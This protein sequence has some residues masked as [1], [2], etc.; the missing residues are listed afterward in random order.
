MSSPLSPF[1]ALIAAPHHHRLIQENDQVRI[2]ETL[3]KPGETVPLHTHEWPAVTTILSWSDFIWRDERGEVTLDTVGQGLR[4]E[5]GE[6]SWSD[7]LPLHSLENVGGK[8]L[9]VI[10]VE[11]KPWC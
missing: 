4:N 7:P 11:I 3:V 1:D 2:I 6:T 9:R 10:M 5:G 8:D